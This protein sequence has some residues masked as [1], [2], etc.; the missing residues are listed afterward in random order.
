VVGTL[1]VEVLREGVHSGDAGGIVPSSFRIARQLL[2]RLEDSATGEIRPTELHAAPPEAR[3]AQARVAAE[4]LGSATHDRFPWVD[5]MRAPKAEP[6]DLVLSRTWR[7]SLE[8][9]GADGLPSI[10]S[11]GN[12]L[13]PRTAL[14]LSLRLPPTV[15]ARQASAVVK[16]CLESDPPHGA[17][18][19]FTGSGQSGWN[20]PPLAPWLEQALERASRAWFGS[21]PAVMGEGGAIPFMGMLGER[22]PEAQFIITGVLGPGSNA[23]G[24]NEFLDLPTAR[25]LTGCVAQ[26]V[27]EHAGAGAQRSPRRE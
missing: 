24:P 5:G 21:P 12:V 16:Q 27:A 15:D 3:L 22:F 2:D 13:R 6:S 18:I 19:R 23:H 1:E 8:V 20:A 9:I 10:G 14:R 17:K 11:S 7:P 25:R 4:I 26:L